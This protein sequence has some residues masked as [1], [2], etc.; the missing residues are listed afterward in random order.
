[1]KN[2]SIILSK[3]MMCVMF[4]FIV[5]SCTKEGPAGPAGADGTNGT[6]GTNGIDG[7]AGCIT[8][9]DADQTVSSKQFQ[10]DVS[11]HAAGN[12][13][14]RSSSASCS[15]CHSQQGFILSDG[16]NPLTQEEWVGVDDPLTLNCYTCHPV[17]TTYTGEDVVSLNFPDQ[18]NWAVTYGKTVDMDLGKGNTC[19]H[20]HQSR[21]RDP[22][23]DMNDLTAMYTGISTH[24]GPHYSSQAN[25]L[26]GFGAYEFEGSTSYS[27]NYHLAANDG[28]VSCHM[29]FNTASITGGHSMHIDVP[30]DLEPAC[31]QCHSDGTDA[32]G[33]YEEYYHT[34]FATIDHDGDHPTLNTTSYYTMLGDALTDYGVYTKV[35]DSV[36]GYPDYVNYNIIR[37]IEINGT[38]TA[39]MFNHRFLY[40][41]HSHGMH[42]PWYAKALLKNSLEAVNAL[43]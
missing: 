41:D 18:P 29:G 25:T 16:N 20:C 10:W 6:N 21:T 36:D 15:P 22:I 32:E 37:D 2:F 31:A 35:V 9:H 5:A 38:L 27:D 19:A 7:T 1:M 42:N 33:K 39:A 28:C 13:L 11:M 24:Y 34:Y 14:G 4:I 17:H 23:V 12:A 3:L 26:G 40:Q 8:C 43:N 30:G